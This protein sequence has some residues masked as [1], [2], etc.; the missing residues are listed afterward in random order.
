MGVWESYSIEKNFDE[1]VEEIQ[2]V[3]QWTM[4]EI[5]KLEESTNLKKI[6]QLK[7]TY[8]SR[9]QV[10]LRENS[11]W[12]SKGNKYIMLSVPKDFYEK[13]EDKSFL[14]QF[15]MENGWDSVHFRLYILEENEEKFE[16]FK[17]IIDMIYEVDQE[18]HKENLRIVEDNRKIEKTIFDILETVGIRKT[19][20]GYKTSR[21]TK[22][23]ELYY[24][25]PSEIRKQIPTS[26]SEDVLDER[27]K[28]LLNQINRY[29]E[30][31][32]SKIRE[33]RLKKEQEQK[34]KE[35][36]RKLALLLA[37]YDLSLDC[38]WRDVL[39]VILDKNKYL[40][41]AH[42]LEKN[43]GDWSNGCNYAEEGLNSF[44]I[45]NELDQKIYDCIHFYIENWFEYMDGRVFRDCEYNYSVLYGIAEEQDANLV[46]DYY[47]VMKYI[48][49][50]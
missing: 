4:N 44:T 39:E 8:L 27:K 10:N 37:K 23:T 15:T 47:E 41:L 49:E 5:K 24:H 11:S 31:E 32:I 28:D 38:D 50:Y 36:N 25:F 14:S 3:K 19:Y 40:R 45:E 29:W 34:E 21:S 48:D 22:K 9:T 13:L 35:K 26:Y 18:I 46:S 17:K 20:Y 7:S 30:Q 12:Y 42:Y 2:K 33:E 43:R 6:Q 16:K 1:L